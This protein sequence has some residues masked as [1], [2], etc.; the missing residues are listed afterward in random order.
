M[1]LLTKIFEDKMSDKAK[2]RLRYFKTFYN[3]FMF[4]FFVYLMLSLRMM[5]DE[6]VQNGYVQCRNE[7]AMR[8]QT[9][10]GNFSIETKA[11]CNDTL[12][13]DYYVVVVNNYTQELPTGYCACK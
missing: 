6:G 11:K 10:F 8:E 4:C 13:E 9:I 7:I 5:Y 2:K 3:I 12:C 1:G